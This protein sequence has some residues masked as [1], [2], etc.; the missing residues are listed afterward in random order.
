MVNGP[1]LMSSGATTN[2]GAG[3]KLPGFNRCSSSSSQGWHRD[4]P[5][6]VDTA[7]PGERCERR[8]S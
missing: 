1:T 6:E 2:P 8:V 3:G 4:G 7:E 5:E